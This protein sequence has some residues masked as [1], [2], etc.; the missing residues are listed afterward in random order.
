MALTWLHRKQSERHLHVTGR[1]VLLQAGQPSRRLAC[2]PVHDPSNAAMVPVAFVRRNKKNRSMH[3]QNTPAK[4][5]GYE[6]LRTWFLGIIAL[7]LV[8]FVLVQGRF[9]LASLVFALLIFSLTAQAMSFVSRIKFGSWRITNWLASI[10]A[11]MVIALALLVVSALFVSQANYVVSQAASLT[12][13]SVRKL[14]DLAA[15]YSPEAAELV[16]T[17]IRSIDINSYLRAMASQASNALSASTFIILF[18]GFLFAERF[19]FPKKLLNMVGSEASA[20]KVMEVIQSIVHRI[21][22]YLLV[23]SIISALTAGVIYVI[24]KGFGIELA[25]PIAIIT[26]VL[27]YIPSIGSILATLLLGLLALVQLDPAMAA[28]IVALAAVT[29]FTL[30]SVLDPMLMGQTLRISAFGIIISLAFWSALWGIPGAFLAVPIMVAI[31]V[32]CTHIPSARPLA[33]LLSRDGVLE[34]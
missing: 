11:W 6:R 21:N 33:I 12:N 15:L 5:D 25:L 8:L 22:R 3:N 29:Q 1:T 27:N 24:S 34:E 20:Q 13:Q 7:V 31:K 26:F 23:K 28:V 4:I 16:E 14:S 9:I 2:G 10:V 17:S 30:G 19:W 18:V 32:T